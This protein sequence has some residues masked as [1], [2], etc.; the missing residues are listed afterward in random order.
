MYLLSSIFY[1]FCDDIKNKSYFACSHSIFMVL[2]FPDLL[3]T[4]LMIYSKPSY[5]KK[6]KYAYLLKKSYICNK[7]HG[8]ISSDYASEIHTTPKPVFS[9]QLI[10]SQSLKRNTLPSSEF[11]FQRHLITI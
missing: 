8:A 6:C 1:L 5:K 3:K 7:N 9:C 4:M 11:P 2:L 10:W